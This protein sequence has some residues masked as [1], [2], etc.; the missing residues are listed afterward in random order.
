MIATRE[1]LVAEL[2]AAGATRE[3][4]ERRADATFGRAGARIAPAGGSRSAATLAPRT[5]PIAPQG[6]QAPG[7]VTI[8]DPPFAV[9][10]GDVLTLT[11]AVPPRTKKN[12]PRGVAKAS[13]A[14]VR[15]AYHLRA[16]LRP[17]AAALGLPLP[18]VP[19][20][21]AARF[22]VDNDR[23]D[24]VGLLQGL[25]DALQADAAADWVGV[26]TDD[27]WLRTFDGTDQIHAPL[28]PHVVLTL[29]PI[30]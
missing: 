6:R 15:F 9:R 21:C 14:Y 16:L 2:V 26:V 20:N 23:A 17:H 5:A 4:A 29:T 13:G 3:N 11:L 19:Y 1:R 27:R 7:A 8:G 12:S 25:C 18:E 24:T 28:R 10:H 30:V 22:H